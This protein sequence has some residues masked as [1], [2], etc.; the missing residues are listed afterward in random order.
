MEVYLV[1]HG[2]AKS[3]A[4][5]PRR[6]LSKRGREEVEKLGRAVGQKGLGV[7]KIL[8]SDKA[9]AR[10]TAKILARYLSPP[11]GMCEIKGLGPQDDPLLARAELEATEG[12]LMLVGHLPH[13]SRLAS[14][15]VTGNPEGKTVDFPAAA[16]VCLSR[17]EG[18]WKV[19]WILDPAS[20]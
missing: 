4:E 17:S 12:P 5:D 20:A 14:L 2:E 7:A 3:E 13:L 1:R 6:P 19:K 9:R 11:G 18:G 16:L 15:L 8:H 10:E